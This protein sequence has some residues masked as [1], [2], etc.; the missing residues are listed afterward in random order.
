MSDAAI[1]ARRLTLI[2]FEHAAG[3][4]FGC[5]DD[6]VSLPQA[7]ALINATTIALATFATAVAAT[8]TYLV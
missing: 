6:G 5:D 4:A 1:E 8:I 3:A 2:R 7:R